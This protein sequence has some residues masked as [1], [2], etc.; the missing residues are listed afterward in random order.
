MEQTTMNGSQHCI[1]KTRTDLVIPQGTMGARWD[2]QGKWNL[3]LV[4]EETGEAIEPSS[5]F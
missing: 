5:A 1:T 4:D 2:K 3:K